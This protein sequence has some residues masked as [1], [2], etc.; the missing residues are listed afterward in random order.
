M[1]GLA[2]LETPPE[3]RTDLVPMGQDR[4][5]DHAHPLPPDR[6]SRAATVAEIRGELRELWNSRPGDRTL[7]ATLTSR[8]GVGLASVVRRPTTTPIY[9]L[10]LQARGHL[11]EFKNPRAW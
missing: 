1:Q 3:S 7:A 10:Y 8:Y 6:R 2:V 9:A 5:R 11:M 4:G